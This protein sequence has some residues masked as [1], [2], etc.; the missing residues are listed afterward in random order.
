MKQIYQKYINSHY[1]KGLNENKILMANT[2]E[3]IMD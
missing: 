2:D 3:N 1:P